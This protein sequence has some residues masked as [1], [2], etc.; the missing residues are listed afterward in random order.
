MVRVA[1]TGWNRAIGLKRGQSLGPMASAFQWLCTIGCVLSPK[2]PI[3]LDLTFSYFS[4]RP[5]LL[6]MVSQAA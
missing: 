2:F 1:C 3:G 5:F 4:F 6:V